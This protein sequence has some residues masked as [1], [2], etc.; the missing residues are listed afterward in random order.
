MD[1]DGD[2]SLYTPDPEC[3]SLGYH[4]D[5]STAPDPDG[6]GIGAPDDNCLDVANPLQQDYD[7]DGFGNACDGDVNGATVDYGEVNVLDYLIFA[8]ALTSAPCVGDPEYNAAADLNSSGCVNTADYFLF[9]GQYAQGAPG[10]SG[11]ACRLVRASG[12]RPG[13]EPDYPCTSVTDDRDGD[14]VKDAADNCP[15][16]WNPVQ[17]PIAGCEQLP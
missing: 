1:W 6:D 4:D 8:N 3:F 5:E 14:G 17:T 11:L 12:A 2:F 10:P 13:D 9:G 16:D 7:L 15:K